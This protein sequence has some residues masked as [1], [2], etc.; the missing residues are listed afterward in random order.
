[1]PVLPYRSPEP[2]GD[3]VCQRPTALV[4]GTYF[5]RLSITV[6]VGRII[7]KIGICAPAT[8]FTRE[9]ANRVIA[10]AIEHHQ[11]ADLI[12]HKQC[13]IEKG[14]FAGSDAKRLGAFVA[15]ANDPAFDAIWFVRGGYGS[16]RIAED[17]VKALKAPARKKSYMGYSDQG[18][19]LGALYKAGIGWPV[20]GPMPGDIRRMGGDKAVLRALDW[21]VDGNARVLE[22][23]MQRGPKYAAFNALTLAMMIGTP[24]MPDLKDHVLMIEEVSEHDYAFDRAMFTITTHLKGTGLAGIRL[25]RISDV[26]ENDRPFGESAVQIAKR[27]C[28]KNGIAYLGAADIGHDIDNKVVP[29]G[30]LA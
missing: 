12:F 28:A 11:A 10:L 27:W 5:D 13:F 16:C 2:V 7:V 19:L 24:I 25:G 22:K 29:F 17:A 6:I 21:L 20:H 26:P 23:H 3:E 8:P 9:D 30:T 14:H 4:G 1:M 18:N 15:M